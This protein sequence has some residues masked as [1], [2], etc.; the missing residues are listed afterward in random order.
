MRGTISKVE[1][2]I[3]AFFPSR[4]RRFLNNDLFQVNSTQFTR[5]QVT[6]TQ[7]DIVSKRFHEINK[8]DK[9]CGIS[10]MSSMDDTSSKALTIKE[11]LAYYV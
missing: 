3:T 7:G 8:F 2:K 4:S 5:V 6:F 9:I 10:P 11:E 1:K